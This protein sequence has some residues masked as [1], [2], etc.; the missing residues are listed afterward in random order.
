M[1][2]TY[3]YLTETTFY[4]YSR[5]KNDD[6]Y[7]LLYTLDD[8]NNPLSRF[9]HEVFAYSLNKKHKDQKSLYL[10]CGYARIAKAI[11]IME[12]DVTFIHVE[13]TGREYAEMWDKCREQI[14]KVP[15]DCTWLASSFKNSFCLQV[16]FDNECLRKYQNFKMDH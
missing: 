11:K 14:A 1:G 5:K 13:F 6:K 10:Y 12:N 9:K 3:S 2:N 4:I 15:K 16:N 7:H 8:N